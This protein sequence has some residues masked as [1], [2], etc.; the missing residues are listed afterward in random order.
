MRSLI[1]TITLLSLF[2]CSEGKFMQREGKQIFTSGNCRLYWQGGI[3]LDGFKSDLTN[4]L[5]VS[6]TRNDLNTSMIILRNRHGAAYNHLRTSSSVAGKKSIILNYC[7][8][9]KKY[10]SAK[11]ANERF[12]LFKRKSGFQIDFSFLVKESNTTCPSEV[13]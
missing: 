8:Y 9:G 6:C 1:F 5:V 7:R 13:E 3:P 12:E 4:E 11:K 10:T 2:G